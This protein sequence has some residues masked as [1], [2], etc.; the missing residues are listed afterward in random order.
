M[1]DVKRYKKALKRELGV[2]GKL[3]VFVLAYK[4]LSCKYGTNIRVR[5]LSVTYKARYRNWKNK[6]ETHSISCPKCKGIMKIN[7]SVDGE[8]R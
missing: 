4:C 1:T 2:C 7:L 6:E 8:N 5:P 3:P